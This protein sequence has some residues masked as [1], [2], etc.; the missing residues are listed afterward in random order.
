MEQPAL[1][2]TL[3]IFKSAFGLCRDNNTL[4]LPRDEDAAG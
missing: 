1:D 3:P 2:Q 4:V